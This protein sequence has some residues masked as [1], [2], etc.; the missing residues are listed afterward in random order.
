MKMVCNWLQLARLAIRLP[1][2]LIRL[3]IGVIR[4]SPTTISDN[5]A[6]FAMLE[7]FS[8]TGGITNDLVSRILRHPRQQF[9]RAGLLSSLNRDSGINLLEELRQK[10]YVVFP[11][12]L[13]EDTCE[14]LTNFALSIPGQA[15]GID[16]G[17]VHQPSNGLYQRLNPKSVIFQYDASLIIENVIIQDL[18]TDNSIL[19]LVQEYLGSAPI[20]DIVTL[21]WSTAYKAVPD[22][23]AAQ[24]WHFDMDRPKW[25]KVFF[26]LTEVGPENGPHSFIEGTHRNGGIPFSLR[27][28]GYTRLTDEEVECHFSAE[29]IK[30]FTG[31]RG[32]VIIEDT[33]GLHKGNHLTAGDRLIL[34]FE[35]CSSLF[36]GSW[37]TIRTPEVIGQSFDRQRAETPVLFQ[38]FD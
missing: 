19:N 7:A 12:L 34:Q 9:S 13:D 20:I 5:T 30:D 35:Y 28:K 15:R 26:Y 37:S 33:R 27:S 38:V 4:Y 6:Y 32:T 22:K 14:K 8:I 3:L 24:Y 31:S 17:D 18:L 11:G 2:S 10:G 21:W 23:N 25:L 16:E 1:I 36:G 29:Q